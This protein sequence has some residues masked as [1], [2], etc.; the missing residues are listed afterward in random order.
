MHC[1]QHRRPFDGLAP[2]VSST[3]FSLF[4]LHD[5]GTQTSVFSRS[6]RRQRHHQAQHRFPNS[7][8]IATLSNAIAF[9]A[10]LATAL[11]LASA[12]ALPNTYGQFAKGTTIL[13]RG[14]TWKQYNQTSIQF[15]KD[16]ICRRYIDKLT[17]PGT[18][19]L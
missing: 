6:A 13:R 19:G 2:F 18:D 15:A 10:A 12:S 8:T 1:Q 4:F 14:E 11:P 7:V 17:K 5:L 16:G 9:I 3:T